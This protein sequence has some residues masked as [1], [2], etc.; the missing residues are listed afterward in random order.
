MN[1][2]PSPDALVI[3]FRPITA[4]AVLS[5]AQ[6][7]ARRS[8]KYR[9]SVFADAPRVDETEDS[10]IDRLLRASELTGVS[11]DGN[12]KYWLCARA[13]EL[14]VLGYAFVKDGYDSEIPEHYSIDLG[15]G[16]TVEDTQLLVAQFEVRDRQQDDN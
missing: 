6:K 10:L 2:S 5:S 12:P 3:R 14:L 4:A 1:S 8:G 16:P 7:E 9:I 11:R 13:G 15:Q